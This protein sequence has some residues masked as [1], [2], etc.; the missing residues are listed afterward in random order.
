MGAAATSGPLH[1]EWL[2]LKGCLFDPITRLPTLPAVVDN[3]RVRLER[4]ETLGLL[5]VDLS[6]DGRYE[7]IYGWQV[8]D[9]MLRLVAQRL[10]A[11]RGDL[12]GLDDEL[13]QV[14][15]RAGEFV[16]FLGLD[17]P[18]KERLESIY[19]T[20][21]EDLRRSLEVAREL[22]GQPMP[23]LLTA[24]V[25]IDSVPT[26]RPERSIYQCLQEARMHCRAQS[27]KRQTGRL[28]DLLRLLE[29]R[30]LVIRY[31]PILDLTDGHIHGFEALSA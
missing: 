19:Q 12:Y 13:A 8:Y 2:K 5:Y 31:Q 18:A 11:S 28:A 14:S 15:I 16:L 26:I 6:S 20:V 3:V 4:G 30:N 23:P 17:E 24:A 29:K 21:S 7:A 1:A 10:Q 22:S 27:Q 25:A 9:H